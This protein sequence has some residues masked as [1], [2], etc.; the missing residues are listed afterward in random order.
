MFLSDCSD[1][2]VHGGSRCQPIVNEN[3]GSPA[4]ARGRRVTAVEAF[5]SGQFPA[6]RRSRKEGSF[7]VP[8][9]L[10]LDTC[11]SASAVPTLPWVGMRAA[12]YRNPD[13]EYGHPCTHKLTR[14]ASGRAYGTGLGPSLVLESRGRRSLASIGPGAMGDDPNPWLLLQAVSHARLQSA[15][16]DP[17]FR[18]RIEALLDRKRQLT[19]SDAWFQKTHPGSALRTIA[20]FSM[21]Y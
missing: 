10:L 21:E 17:R 15:K 4:H 2:A 11:I 7:I 19:Q 8:R 12:A 20:Y 5:A 14:G 9:L 6:L 13:N 1:S 18:E 16:S 3:Y